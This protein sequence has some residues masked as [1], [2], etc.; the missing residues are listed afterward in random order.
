MERPVTIRTIPWALALF[1]AAALVHVG[2]GGGSGSGARTIRIEGSDTMVNLAQAWAERYHREHPGVSVQVQG[3]GSGVG[4]ASMTDGNCDIAASSREIRPRER[5]RIAAQ[6]GQPEEHIVG[7]DALAIYVNRSNPLEEITLEQLAEIYGE[8]G[9]ITR[10]SQL[11]GPDIEI[12]RVSRQNN[13]GTYAYFR[14]AVLGKQREYKLGSIDQSGSKDVVA[15]VATTPGAI[16]Y[17][18]MGYATNEIKLLKV[19]RA[20][21]EPAYAPTVENVLAGKYPITRPL[22]LY[23]CGEPH[24]DVLKFFEWIDSPEG[25]AIVVELGYIPR[26]RGK[27]GLGPQRPRS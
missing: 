19:A 6:R 14:E 26:D 17:S 9:T 8:G 10:W 5:E 27:S 20:K 7:F 2:C 15:L 18:G 22:Y 16:G 12:T 4:F 21:G 11:G 24:D 3:G 25:Q 23:T 1:C 13:S